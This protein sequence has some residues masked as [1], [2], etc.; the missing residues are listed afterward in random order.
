MY[1]TRVTTAVVGTAVTLH[2]GGERYE[3]I[4]WSK[5][6]VH[7]KTDGLYTDGSQFLISNVTWANNGTY[8]CAYYKYHPINGTLTDSQT[9]QLVVIRKFIPVL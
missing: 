3:F 6:G 4:V 8:V 1:P 9:V 5:D 7:I 2:C